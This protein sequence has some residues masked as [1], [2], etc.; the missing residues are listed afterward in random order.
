MS[1]LTL[2][3]DADQGGG[4]SSNGLTAKTYDI[5][6]TGGSITIANNITYVTPETLGIIDKPIGSFSGARQITGSLTMYLNTTGSS[7]SGNGSNQLLSDLANATDL[8]RNEF[9]MSLFM[10]GASS[11]TPVVEFDIP[12]AHL[13]VPAIEVADLI[14]VS[15]EF[16]A[17]G[18]NILTGDEMT[19]KY[20][21]LTSHSDATY[22][23][24]LTV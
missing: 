12:K 7:G 3:V 10:G 15:V 13:Q 21:G 17:H 2:A 20:K 8:V 18:S 9:N 23:S 16:A 11:D 1:T 14:S 4:A 6:I 19:V 24:N 5:A 22:A